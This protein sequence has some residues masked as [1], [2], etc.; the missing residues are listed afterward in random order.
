MNIVN[1]KRPA[2]DDKT[3]LDHRAILSKRLFERETDSQAF[4][5]VGFER[6]R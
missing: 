5:S 4:V 2:N 6:S 3:R 1:A